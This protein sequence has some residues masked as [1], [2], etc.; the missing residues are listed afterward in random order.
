MKSS[1]HPTVANILILMLFKLSKLYSY[2]EHSMPKLFTSQRKKQWIDNKIAAPRLIEDYFILS[3][4]QAQ[5]QVYIDEIDRSVSDFLNISQTMGS[6]KF[7]GGVDSSGFDFLKIPPIDCV[8]TSPPYLQAQEY[9]RTFK[10]EMMWAGIPSKKIRSYISNEI[11]FRKTND[12]LV[13]NYFAKKRNEIDRKDLLAL[14]DSYFWFTIQALQ[15][16]AACLKKDGYLCVL[17]GNPKMQGI[18][19]EIWK[20]IY[21]HFV[22]GLKFKFIELYEDRIVYR[23]LFRG[24]KN[25]NP[26]WYALRVLTGT[27]E[28]LVPTTIT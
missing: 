16:S 17:V 20:V 21:E 7:Y 5:G 14:Y 6:V 15:K 19:V 2:A 27:Q 11:P 3:E 10:L 18:E 28:N 13:G 1:Q 24:R 4:I 26:G 9:M 25:P 8:V 23:K 22:N 12:R